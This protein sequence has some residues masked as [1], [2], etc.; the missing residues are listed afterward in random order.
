[1]LTYYCA[2]NIIPQNKIKNHRWQN[3]DEDDDNA[4]H[5]LQRNEIMKETQ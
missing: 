4:D 2:I 3:K 1:M 5:S